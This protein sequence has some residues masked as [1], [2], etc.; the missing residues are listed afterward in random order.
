[1]MIKRFMKVMMLAQICASTALAVDP[2]ISVSIRQRYPWN[3]LVDL[4]FTITG[5][6]G[7]QYATSFTAKDMVGNTNITMA[8][9]RKADGMAANVANE[10]LLP[11]TYKWVWDAAAD[12]PED[13]KCDNVTVTGTAVESTHLYM[14][15]DLSSGSDSSSYPVSYLD[16]VPSGGWSDTYK[17]TKLVLRRCEA[18]TYKMQSNS[19]VTLTKPYYLC[20]SPIKGNCR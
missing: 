16:D 15:V 9:V 2:A 1:M 12:L 3:G 6:E 19:N 17:T 18:G 20:F 7:S 13:W 5:E 10:Q 11:G 14:V 8:T 4:H